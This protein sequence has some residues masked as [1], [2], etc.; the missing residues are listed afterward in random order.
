[1]T[2]W[3][4]NKLI[5]NW[6][7]KIAIRWLILLN[8]VVPSLSLTATESNQ[9]SFTNTSS[10]KTER[11]ISDA[12]RKAISTVDSMLS[13]G[14]YEYSVVVVGIWSYRRC[15]IW[16]KLI[17]RFH[18]Q[19]SFEVPEMFLPDSLWLA[20]CRPRWYRSNKLIYTSTNEIRVSIYLFW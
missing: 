8:G 12:T 5:Q 3:F 9:D 10:I 2:F 15:Q 7:L 6:P 18:P 4:L 20:H 17:D 16:S 11:K 1:M 14:S 13:S 19:Q